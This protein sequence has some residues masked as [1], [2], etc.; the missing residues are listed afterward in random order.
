MP[1]TWCPLGPPG[2][3]PAWETAMRMRASA[4][5]GLHSWGS[6]AATRLWKEMTG[7][8]HPLPRVTPN[9]P[10]SPPK[11]LPESIAPVFLT[12]AATPTWPGKLGG[13]R[14]T[15]A[16]GREMPP[17]GGGGGTRWTNRL[18]KE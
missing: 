10:G 9:P 1:L 4:G 16:M 12:P 11:A 2:E 6:R 17:W 18:A 3:L 13:V 14:V 5:A 8:A 15:G 7:W